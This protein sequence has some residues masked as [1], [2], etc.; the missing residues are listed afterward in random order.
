[1][2]PG[3]LPNINF[4]ANCLV[5]LYGLDMGLSYEITFEYLRQLAIIIRGGV[6][7]KTKE[8][9]KE[10]YC[11]QTISSLE[12]WAKVISTHASKEVKPNSYSS[13]TNSADLISYQ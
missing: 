6:S 4:M 13:E 2:S 11:W 5:D 7:Q 12:L 1:M 8:A 10:V 3:T 9:Y